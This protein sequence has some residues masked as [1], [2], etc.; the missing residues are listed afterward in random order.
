MAVLYSWQ[1]W[2][3]ATETT[4]P[5]KSKIFTTWLFLDK[6]CWP[7]HED[8]V[9]VPCFPW[10]I[11]LIMQFAWSAALRASSWSYNSSHCEGEKLVEIRHWAETLQSIFDLL[12][13][14]LIPKAQ[15]PR[16]APCLCS[17]PFG[18]VS[19]SSGWKT[20]TEAVESH[21]SR[22]F[23]PILPLVKSF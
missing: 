17:W 6:I 22:C 19:G 2:R 21:R 8:S 11:L 18:L 5:V 13:I 12:P 4:G 23:L 15:G 16:A 10:T 7:R 3:N 14:P 1:G 9:E 20:T